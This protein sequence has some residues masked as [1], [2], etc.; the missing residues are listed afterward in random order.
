MDTGANEQ[1]KTGCFSSWIPPWSRSLNVFG[2]TVRCMLLPT[3]GITGM[4]LQGLQGVGLQPETL[5]DQLLETFWVMVGPYTQHI[6]NQLEQLG[7]DHQ[8]A[9]SWKR[10][11]NAESPNERTA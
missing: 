1:R 5:A 8:L 10:G 4:C 6:L 3:R 11:R 7:L 9:V 2:I